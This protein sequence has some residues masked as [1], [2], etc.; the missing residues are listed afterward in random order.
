ML[1]ALLT[2]PAAGARQGP[3]RE[4]PVSGTDELGCRTLCDGNIMFLASLTDSVRRLLRTRSA[5]LRPPILC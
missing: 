2:L 5:R 3:S 4:Y 1:D